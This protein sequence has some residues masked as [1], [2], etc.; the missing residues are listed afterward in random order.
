M[1]ATVDVDANRALVPAPEFVDIGEHVW[2]MRDILQSYAAGEHI[3]LIG[4]RA[5]PPTH[6]L[7]VSRFIV[8]AFTVR[9]LELQ[10]VDIFQRYFRSTLQHLLRVRV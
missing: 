10:S 6:P 1:T 7:A 8:G 4:N 5:I 9:I 3:L 2:L